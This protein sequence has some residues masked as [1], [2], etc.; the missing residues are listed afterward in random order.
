MEVSDGVSDPH[1]AKDSETSFRRRFG[2]VRAAS[3]AALCSPVATRTPTITS[4]RDDPLYPRIART[5]EALLKSGN[6]VAPVDVLIGMG[7]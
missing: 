6:V 4:D 3:L 5:V 7:S 2:V 1:A